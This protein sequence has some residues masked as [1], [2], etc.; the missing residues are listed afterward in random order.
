MRLSCPR[1]ITKNNRF[2]TEKKIINI[3][4]E[5]YRYRKMQPHF[6]NPN[7]TT[8]RIRGH[9]FEFIKIARTASLE[10]RRINSDIATEPL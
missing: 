7:E 1:I 2:A 5:F 4:R 3:E 9:I 8:S 10:T 6:P